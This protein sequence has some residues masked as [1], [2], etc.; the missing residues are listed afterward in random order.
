[1]WEQLEGVIK[2]TLSK[3]TLADLVPKEARAKN[4]D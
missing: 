4:I 2:N 1:V 3:V